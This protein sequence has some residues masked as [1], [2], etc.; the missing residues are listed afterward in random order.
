M[1]L[2]KDTGLPKLLQCFQPIR[3][4]VHGLLKNSA[5]KLPYQGGLCLT[6]SKIEGMRIS[7]DPIADTGFWIPPD[8]DLRSAVE[9]AL[10][11]FEDLRDERD[12]YREELAKQDC[13]T[14]K[15]AYFASKEYCGVLMNLIYY[16][17]LRMEDASGDFTYQEIWYHPPSYICLEFRLIF[18][19]PGRPHITIISVQ[20]Q[21][22]SSQ[23]ELL[24]TEFWT[25]YLWAQKLAGRGLNTTQRCLPVSLN[26]P[27]SHLWSTNN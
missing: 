3:Y 18:S 25:L 7:F 26:C 27:L 24:C 16:S 23:E 19:S 9:Q 5:L 11:P 21:R 10:E 6:R 20:P 12:F 14:I 22:A 17:L 15:H 1:S 8:P 2:R 4:H 13:Q